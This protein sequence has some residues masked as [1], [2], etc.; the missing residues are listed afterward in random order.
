MNGNARFWLILA[1]VLV[2]TV[3]LIGGSGSDGPPY[4]PRAV[5]PDGARGVVESLERLGATVDLDSPVPGADT[6]TALMLQDRL[7]ADDRMATEQWVRAGGTLLVADPASDL[8]ARRVGIAPFTQG[9]GECTIEALSEVQELDVSGAL[10]DAFGIDSCFGD[11]NRAFIV[12]ERLD[13]GVIVT[14]GSPNIFV[15]SALDEGDAAVVALGVLAPNRNDR[16]A[17]LGPS[18]VDFGEE[19]LNQLVAPRVVNAIFQLLAAFL[20][21]AL[22]RSR[23]LGGVVP[24]PV[25]VRIEGSELVLKAGLL[26]QRAKDPASAAEILR[27]DVIERARRLLAIAPDADDQ[28]VADRLASRTAYSPDDVY[29]ALTSPVSSDQE[30]AT[31]SHHL[32]ELDLQL[33]EPASAQTPTSAPTSS[34]TQTSTSTPESTVT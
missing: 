28:V 18:L 27:R 33:H 5:N 6:A 21:F 12:A 17:F 7:N 16:V 30:L 4:D 9:R 10:L 13:D 11:G 8:A 1:A 15:N 14:V 20:L 32:A 29:A 31:V 22:Y 34:S 2:V 3:L 23:R 19:G 25:P 24:E 26:S